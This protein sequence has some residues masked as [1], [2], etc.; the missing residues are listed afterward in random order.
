MAL[1][2]FAARAHAEIETQV[3]TQTETHVESQNESQ[4]QLVTLPADFPSPLTIAPPVVRGGTFSIYNSDRILHRENSTG[5]GL[6]QDRSDFKFFG[7]E[8]IQIQGTAKWVQYDGVKAF[9]SAETKPSRDL[10]VAMSAGAG[11]LR[12]DEFFGKTYDKVLS[13]ALWRLRTTFEIAQKTELR[14]EV[15][16]DFSYL[17]WVRPDG[18][19]QIM[20]VENLMLET[21]SFAIKKWQA[22]A[23]FHEALLG[24]TNASKNLDLLLLRELPVRNLQVS[25]GVGAGLLAFNRT[26]PTYWSPTKFNTYGLRVA[27]SKSLAD[28]WNA[29]ARLAYG[30]HRDGAN[31]VGK[32][33]AA[34]M[35]LQYRARAGWTL[36]LLANFMDSEN[37]G[38]YRNDLGMSAEIPI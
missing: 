21:E 17:S 31:P 20:P 13:I 19:S 11:R 7:V 28:R 36:R 1:A 16:N 9:L 32:E 30:F 15:T 4:L 26:S 6:S 35:H 22:R 3:E 25:A 12:L 10:T 23:T 38:W 33:S 5:I 34:E 18:Q 27:I 24:D 2:F 8:A 37:G 14:A 29:E